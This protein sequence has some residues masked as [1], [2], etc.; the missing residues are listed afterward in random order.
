MLTAESRS[1]ESRACEGTHQWRV[2]RRQSNNNVST[3]GASSVQVDK[4]TFG[5]AKSAE[6]DTCEGAGQCG[7]AGLELA[8]DLYRQGQLDAA[9]RLLQVAAGLVAAGWCFVW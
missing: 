5:A 6:S 8:R 2:T 4:V 7:S 3:S 1:G 9:L